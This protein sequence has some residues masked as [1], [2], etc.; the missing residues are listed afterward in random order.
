MVA[1]SRWTPAR[2][3]PYAWYDAH[4][5]GSSTG[6]TDSSSFAR[7][8]MTVGAGS[9]SPLWLPYSRSGVYLPDSAS[10]TVQSVLSGANLTTA[11]A[12][13][14][15]QTMRIRSTFSVGSVGSTNRKDIGSFWAQGVVVYFT[16]SSRTLEIFTYVNSPGVENGAVVVDL[17]TNGIYYLE[18]AMSGNSFIVR[19]ST[20]G[21]SYQTKG[22]INLTAHA[23]PAGA[24]TLTAGVHQ[25]LSDITLH[26]LEF[27]NGSTP[28]AYFDAASCTQSG[29][30]DLYG[31]VWAITR[32]TS[33][34]KT[35][36][37]SLAAKSAESLFLF[38]TDDFMVVPAAAVPPMTAAD[39]S[40]VVM[41][42]RQWG[43][44]ASFGRW[45]NTKAATATNVAGVDIELN[46]SNIYGVAGDGSNA[47][48]RTGTHTLGTR[49]VATLLQA[50]SASNN[51]YVNNTAF[52]GSGVPGDRTGLAATYNV[53]R[54]V[55]GTLY[56]DFEFSALL[57][58]DRALTATEIA[59]LVAFYK[60]GL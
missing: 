30:T 35:V 11:R 41:V 15:N 5:G 23:D 2:L 7:V 4:Y 45:F 16:P 9:N 46:G 59:L 48:V 44:A 37:R 57:T 27:A 20:D 33:G 14:D 17:P 8:P 12:A 10:S 22:T 32:P 34:R 42:G 6:I 55:G 25:Y 51:F 1:L 19:Q 13:F 43:T 54:E 18:V 28:F 36:V 29:L 47:S 31:N 50:G 60:G 49:T 40:T 26:S 39:S 3:A 52:T 24:V 38:G 21:G 58:F 56:Q 53:G